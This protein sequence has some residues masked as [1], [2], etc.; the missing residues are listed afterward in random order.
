MIFY[1]QHIYFKRY[2]AHFATTKKTGL[3]TFYYTLFGWDINFLGHRLVP[4]IALTVGF[5][6]KF[7]LF[8]AVLPT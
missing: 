3:L 5:T 8:L 6:L 1:Y 4:I 2:A 7:I